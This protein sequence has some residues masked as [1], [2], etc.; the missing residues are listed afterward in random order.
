[1]QDVMIGA[2]VAFVAGLL[3]WPRG[4]G[5]QARA[6]IGDLYRVTL[7]AD[8]FHHV[9]A[10]EATDGATAGRDDRRALDRAR[11]A[12]SDLSA[13]RGHTGPGVAASVRLV[14][15]AATV[16]AAAERIVLLRPVRTPAPP[17]VLTDVDGV[18]AA[19]RGVADALASGGDV[20]LADPAQVGSDRRQATAERL[21]T[22]F[23]STDS[24]VRADA[25]TLVWA[26]EWVVDLVRL[27]A[28][29][30]GPVAELVGS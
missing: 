19:F 10:A 21:A 13:E 1:V 5:H 11:A 28:G 20:A 3:F 4:A 15:T 2:A 29:L 6:A 23:L 22:D 27:T 9:L 7:L 26:G 24:R 25:F 8:A 18:F 30:E 17:A 12:V 16:R 14:V